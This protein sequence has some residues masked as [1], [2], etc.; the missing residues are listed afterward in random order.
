MHVTS[1]VLLLTCASLYF[2]QFDLYKEALLAQPYAIL[3]S[4]ARCFT[5]LWC[6]REHTSCT[7]PTKTLLHARGGRTI[8]MYRAV[9]EN[10]CAFTRSFVS[11]ADA[12]VH[13][14]M[15]PQ[16][17]PAIPVW[18]LD[19]ETQVLSNQLAPLQVPRAP[20]WLA[21]GALEFV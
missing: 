4:T 18:N 14:H 15:M 5:G 12:N 10:A 1:K 2:Q 20:T 8:L 9:L 19:P 7:G 13:I 11:R 17:A 3:L 21:A 6:T 16:L